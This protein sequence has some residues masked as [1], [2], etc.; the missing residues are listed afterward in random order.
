MEL[1]SSLMEKK[2]GHPQDVPFFANRF[3]NRVSRSWLE[4]TPTGESRD[5]SFNPR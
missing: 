1:N 5:P 2:R 4:A 3:K